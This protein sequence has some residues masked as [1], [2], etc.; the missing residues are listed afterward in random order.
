[1]L[2]QGSVRST[3]SLRQRLICAIR[4]FSTNGSLSSPDDAEGADEDA[5]LS[6]PAGSPQA[7]NSGNASA[8]RRVKRMH[9]FMSVYSV[10]FLAVAKMAEQAGPAPDP[11]PTDTVSAQLGADARL[12]GG[13]RAIGT[14]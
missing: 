9:F 11:P 2:V 1:M 5:A 6:L 14:R 7:A 8:Q 10:P 3:S 13:R 12:R 4:S